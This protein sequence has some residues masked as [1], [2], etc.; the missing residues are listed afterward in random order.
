MRNTMI[1]LA[2]MVAMVCAVMAASSSAA[3]AAP[4]MDGVHR[5]L[6]G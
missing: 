6:G 5:A 3:V 4:N 2:W 1:K